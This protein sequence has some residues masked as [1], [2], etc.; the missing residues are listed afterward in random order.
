MIKPSVPLIFIIFAPLQKRDSSRLLVLN[1]NTKSF[2]DKKFTDFVDLLNPN[3]LLIFND[4]RVIKARLFGKKITGGKVEIMIER[5]LDDHHALAHLKTSKKIVDDN[6]F[7][8]N[9]DVSVKV[10]KKENDLFYIEFNSN[11]SSYDILEKYGHIPLPPYIERDADK[12]DE[13]RYQ[14]IYAKESGAVAAPT[15][16]LHFTDEIFKALDDKKIKYTFIEK[17]KT[18]SHELQKK[19]DESIGIKSELI[20]GDFL[21]IN[22]LKKFDAVVCPFFLDLLNPTEMK[23]VSEKFQ[24]LLN[25]NGQILILDF[26]KS[27]T[28]IEKIHIKFLY[29]IFRKTDGIFGNEILEF[30]NHNF[31]E[32]KIVIYKKSFFYKLEA[33]VYE[34]KT[35]NA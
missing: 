4:T 7:E 1:K 14:T 20:F 31:K 24:Y 29:F 32:N 3:D 28:F 27:E 11:L 15:A 22:I 5:I 13:K 8:I 23:L 2:S 12:S 33:K 25:P 16:G 6:I 19:I 30:E 10:I 17:S 35:N 34:K 9:K 21:K 18:F 26:K